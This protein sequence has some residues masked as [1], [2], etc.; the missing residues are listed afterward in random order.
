MVN[1]DDLLKLIDI[2]SRA[3]VKIDKYE[4]LYQ[5][6]G[7]EEMIKL[8]SNGGAGTNEVYVNF[9]VRSIVDWKNVTVRDVLP[10]GVEHPQ[11]DETVPFNRA[12]FDKFLGKN[13]HLVGDLFKGVDKVQAD[14]V[15]E[16]DKVKKK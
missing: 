12:L 11:I 7:G 8:G 9:L 14:K 10:D 13:L 16:K 4:F 1:V 5:K 3:W 6:L 2:Q 15:E